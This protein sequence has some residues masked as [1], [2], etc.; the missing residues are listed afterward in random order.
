MTAPSSISR[1]SSM[2]VE[3]VK[4]R[5]SEMNQRER[6]EIQ[7]HLIRLRTETAAWRK[8]MAR[9]NRD[10]A[11]GKGMTLEEARQKLGV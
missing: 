1:I 6:R 5:I 7:L 4:Q 10:L 11:A 2:S 8:E 9:R 3:E